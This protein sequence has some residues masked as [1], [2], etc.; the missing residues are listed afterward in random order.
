MNTQITSSKNMLIE[1]FSAPLNDATTLKIDVN[2]GFGNLMIDSLPGNGQLLASGALQYFEKQA[3]PTR[4]LNYKDGQATLMLSGEAP[5]RGWLRIP[6][7]ASNGATEWH[8][9][10][11][12]AIP[13][14]ITANSGG[15]NIKLYLAGIPVTRLSTGT[16]GGNIDVVLPDHAAGLSVTAKSGAGTVTLHVPGSMAVKLHATSGLGKIVISSRFNKIDRDTYQTPG[17]EAAANRVEITAS[18]GAGNV[19]I[20]DE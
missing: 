1:E 9:H 6:W 14:D 7:S 3:A 20:R 18:T 10:L 12:P 17:Y 4:T 5:K 2:S 16:G 19:V 13:S 11:N 15:G 8:I